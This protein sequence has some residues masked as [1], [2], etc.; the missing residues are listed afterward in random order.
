MSQWA[1]VVGAKASG[2]FLSL[3][4][5]RA[6]IAEADDSSAKRTWEDAKARWQREGLASLCGADYH[7][8]FEVP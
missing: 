8:V 5:R 6:G 7:G 3:K 1:L 2:W 4:P